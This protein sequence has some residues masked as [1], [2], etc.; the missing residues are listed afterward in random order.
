[1]RIKIT[2]LAYLLILLPLV[3]F[4]ADT[5]LKLPSFANLNS[6]ATEVVDMTFGPFLLSIAGWALEHDEDDDPDTVAVKHLVKGLKSVQ[7]RSY[8]FA[9]ENA[10]SKAD[11]DSVRA[12][13]K[14]PGWSQLMQVR[15][16]AAR[17]D[18]DVYV[19]YDRDK[20]VGL[21][22]IASQP[23]EFSILNIAGELELEHVATLQKHLSLPET[24]ATRYAMR[25]TFY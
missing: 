16:K 15:D 13:L 17:E 6:K 23:K 2:N 11:I 20:I 25:S 8:Q 21:A 5:K 4:A 19:A 7:I 12:Q 24:G 3:A 1:M 22:I 10:Y 18:V 14:R 9:T